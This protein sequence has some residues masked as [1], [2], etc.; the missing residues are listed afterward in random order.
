MTKRLLRNCRCLWAG[1]WLEAMVCTC[2]KQRF[3]LWQRN[4]NVLVEFK[5]LD[6]VS[7][8]DRLLPDVPRVGELVSDGEAAVEVVVWESYGIC[9]I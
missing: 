1:G 8:F 5:D 2:L 4:M 6:G 3:P 7:L 9:R